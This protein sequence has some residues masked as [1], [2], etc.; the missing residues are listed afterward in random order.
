MAEFFISQ[1]DLFLLVGP[2]NQFVC[3]ILTESQENWQ[4]DSPLSIDAQ[5]EQIFAKWVALGV[6]D[7]EPY[8]QQHSRLRDL[9]THSK[10]LLNRI[11]LPAERRPA[12]D[13]E[14]Y[15]LRTCYE[16]ESEEAWTK[17]QNELELFFEGIEAENFD[18]EQY[19][20]EDAMP[21]MTYYSEYLWRLAAG[22]IYIADAKTL[23]SKRRNAGKILVVWYDKCG[24]GIRCYRQNLDEAVVESGCFHYLLKDHACW[25]NAEICESYEEGEPLGPRYG[26]KKD[27][28]S[29]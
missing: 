28:T 15:W 14:P 5:R 26:E 27:E 22:R 19:D 9:P 8:Q 13:L 20:S 24:R 10:E 2:L 29:E 7:R 17:I 4:E 23:A 12:T 11:R 21:W 3:A 6:R 16:P 1:A 18:E 25:E